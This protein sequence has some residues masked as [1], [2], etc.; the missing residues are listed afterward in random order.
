MNIRGSGLIL[1]GLC[2]GIA[3]TIILGKGYIFKDIS[4]IQNESK[5]YYGTDPYAM[6]N[7]I[8]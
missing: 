5:S 1:F 6:R 4:T 8:I 2:F 3:S 7:K